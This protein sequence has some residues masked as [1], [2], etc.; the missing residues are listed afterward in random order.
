MIRR[1]G[2]RPEL[3]AAQSVSNLPESANR[4]RNDLGETWGRAVEYDN[5]WSRLHA[6]GSNQSES[7][8]TASNSR[9]AIDAG[10]GY[11][12]CLRC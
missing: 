2:A 10:D 11:S 1:F 5:R 3:L 7:A 6:I 9:D 4:H 12:V 8:K